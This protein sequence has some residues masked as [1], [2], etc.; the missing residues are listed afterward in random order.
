LIRFNEVSKVFGAG[1]KTVKALE[2]ASFSVEEGEIFGL[3]G[4]NG[5]GKTTSL[6]L[7][8]TLLK[9]TAGTISVA[10]YD[11]VKAPQEVRKR[12]GF[13]SSD[14][15][16]TGGLSAQELLV[17]FGRLNHLTES[18]IKERSGFLVDQ[19][20]M[21]EFY[22]RKVDTYSTGM[23]QKTLIAISLLHDP[24][25]IIFDE[26]TNGL[27]IITGRTVLEILA[28]L[29]KRNKTLII[30]THIMSIA[31]KLCDRA[32]IIHKGEIRIQGTLN[33]IYEKTGESDL[34]EAFFSIIRGDNDEGYDRYPKKRA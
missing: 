21:L 12:I 4:P 29:K 6:R 9:P 8:S 1:K 20:K 28:G 23:K 18:E 3:L 31:S 15:N 27:D 2:K 33:E 26:P 13:L 32:A 5:A 19:L 30:S 10:G 25:I 7:L 16:L 14:M 24:D 34:E 17:F 11:T 22:T